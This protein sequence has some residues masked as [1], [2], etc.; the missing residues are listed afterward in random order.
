MLNTNPT[1]VQQQNEE[2]LI[3]EA[4]A[5]S[6]Y[7]FNKLVNFWYKRI[8]NFCYKY[9]GGHDDAMEATQK[10]FIAMHKGIR[11]LHTVERFKPWLYKIALNK[12]HETERGV[13]RKK[14]VS[15]FTADN[16]NLHPV[17]ANLPSENKQQPERKLM[18]NEVADLVRCCLQQIAPEQRQ[19][20]LL[21]EFEGLKF[22]EIAV[23][24]KISENTAKS[25]LYYGLTALKKLMESMNLN[26][27][28]LDY[29]L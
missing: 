13:F 25:R 21:K 19:V 28:T 10:T 5:G 8:Y 24:L 7:A 29:E 27:N 4:R 16:S 1:L 18:N 20:I 15:L 2:A 26:Q 6:E 14:M 17:V 11:Q 9:S 12:C 23:V 3:C 22:R